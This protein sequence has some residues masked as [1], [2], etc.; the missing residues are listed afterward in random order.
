[1]TMRVV[2]SGFFAVGLRLGFFAVGLRTRD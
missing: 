2:H 1:M